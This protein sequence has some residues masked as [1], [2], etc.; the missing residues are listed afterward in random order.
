MKQIGTE[1]PSPLYNLYKKWDS[2]HLYFRQYFLQK[3]I[4]KIKRIGY[5]FRT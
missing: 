5:T 1:M 3:V 4:D 2:I